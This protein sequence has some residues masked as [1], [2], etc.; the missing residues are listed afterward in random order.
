MQGN[1]KGAC[2]LREDW[3]KAERTLGVWLYVNV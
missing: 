1:G 3:E 2:A